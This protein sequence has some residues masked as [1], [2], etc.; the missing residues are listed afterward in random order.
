MNEP[1]G[2]E[3]QDEELVEISEGPLF[4]QVVTAGRVRPGRKPI[5]GN[6]GD[7]WTGFGSWPSAK[8]LSPA[9]AFRMN[10]QVDWQANFDGIHSVYGNR[11][12]R[13][14]V[15]SPRQHDSQTL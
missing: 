11:Q 1:C 3:C 6:H 10:L 4:F 7:Y 13:L 14:N 9:P 12:M 2:S 8:Y 5:S 15:C